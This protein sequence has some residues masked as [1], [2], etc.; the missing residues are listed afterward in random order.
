MSLFRDKKTLVISVIG[1][2]NSGKST[3]LNYMF[4]TLFDVRDGRCTR[5]IYGSFVK[6]N[7]PDFDYIMLIDT[8]GLMGVERKDPE[9]DRL[10]VLFCLA[11]SHLVIVNMVGEVNSAMETM[12]SLCT[13]SLKQM[14]VTRIPQPTVRFILNQ[15]A[16]LNSDNNRV[17][18]ERTVSDLKKIGPMIDIN[19]CGNLGLKSE[20]YVYFKKFS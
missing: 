5:G 7:R 8:E 13:D 6:S 14:G 16:D 9:Y 1:P 17:A 20:C 4:G 11:V 10:I 19:K 12:L 15:K 3:L 18:I 2:Q